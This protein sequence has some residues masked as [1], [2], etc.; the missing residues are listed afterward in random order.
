MIIYA[1]IVALV[2][3]VFLHSNPFFPFLKKKS[4]GH[5]LSVLFLPPTCSRRRDFRRAHQ[6]ADV[7]L[8]ELVVVV[9]L[10][11][12]F[13]DGF[14]AVEDFDEGFLEDFGVSVTALC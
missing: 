6:V 14:D 5:W 9:E 2:V 13:L 1:L 10:V 8:Q 11:V 7:L 3:S 4:A 12:F